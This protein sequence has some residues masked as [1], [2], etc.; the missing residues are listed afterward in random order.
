MNARGI[1]PNR[2]VWFDTADHDHA[3]GAKDFD[4]LVIAINSAAA[5]VD[6]ADHTIAEFQRD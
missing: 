3:V 1:G 6:A 4:P 5:V 2:G